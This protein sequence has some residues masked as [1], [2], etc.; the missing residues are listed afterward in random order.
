LEMD[1]RSIINN[2]SHAGGSRGNS[3]AKYLGRERKED[4]EE[5]VREWWGRRV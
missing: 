1:Y 3:K 4:R 5:K 2:K